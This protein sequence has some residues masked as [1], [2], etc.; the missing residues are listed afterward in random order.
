MKFGFSIFFFWI[1]Y[2]IAVF[3]PEKLK[4]NPGTLGFVNAKDKSATYEFVD[5]AP[6]SINYYRLRQMDND[7]KET[8][9]KI[10][11]VSF[12]ESN[13]LKVYPNPTA[14][15]LTIET[16]EEGDRQVVNLLGQTVLRSKSTQQLDVSTLPSGTYF[17]KIGGQ[18]ARF[19]KQ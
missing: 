11:T 16:T 14:Q 6:L 9:S 10:L 18:Q 19:V 15:L 1:K 4:S 5:N 8:L 12:T 17:L 7:G 2:K 13:K 3:N